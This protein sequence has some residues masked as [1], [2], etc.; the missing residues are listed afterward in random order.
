[1]GRLQEPGHGLFQ[2]VVRH[3]H[4]VADQLAHDL[5][6]HVRRLAGRQPL[7]DGG[8]PVVLHHLACFEGF[9]HGRGPCGLHPDDSSA[10][11]A[12]GRDDGAPADAAAQADGNEQHIGR[13]LLVED[14]LGHGADAG[15]QIRFIGG[16]H[17]TQSPF[18]YQLFATALGLVKILAVLN[19]FRAQGLHGAVFA[20][21]V[22]FRHHQCAGHAEAPG[23]VGQ[24]LAVIASGATDDASLFLLGGQAADQVNAAPHLEG[25]RGL[26]VLV[27]EQVTESQSLP[28][29]GP[30]VQQGGPQV[31]VH[32]V[33]GPGDIA[34][35]EREH[36]GVKNS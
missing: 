17:I 28:Q 23:G 33:A 26:M 25:P 32:R 34:V 8:D 1:M 35:I 10:G 31:C 19:Q 29:Q 16:M 7:G 15:E 21:V 5:Q 6:G 36:F 24:G 12:P 30:F 18:R 13:R 22:V 14:L 20:G 11:V 3:Q 9:R 2:L 4:D 27:L